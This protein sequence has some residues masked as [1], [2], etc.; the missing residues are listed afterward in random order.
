MCYLITVYKKK[1]YYGLSPLFF[2]KNRAEWCPDNA[3]A[4]YILLLVCSNLTGY[5]VHKDLNHL[6]FSLEN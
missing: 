1:I 2:F 6:F 5:V 3:P 4:L